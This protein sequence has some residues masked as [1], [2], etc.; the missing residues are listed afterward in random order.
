M[1]L[2][3]LAL[4]VRPRWSTD[5]YS[6]HAFA[7]DPRLGYP[8]KPPDT[9]E[10]ALKGVT[11]EHESSAGNHTCAD[12]KAGPEEFAALG[13][14]GLADPWAKWQKCHLPAAIRSANWRKG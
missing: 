4:T 12:C 9:A 2:L 8:G 3:T 6:T 13:I 1:S 7:A 14:T 11:A 5:L 10:P